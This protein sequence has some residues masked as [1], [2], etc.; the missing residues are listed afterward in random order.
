MNTALQH[1][2]DTTNRQDSPTQ[3]KIQ[4]S[5]VDCPDLSIFEGKQLLAGCTSPVWRKNGVKYEQVWEVDKGTD[6]VSS[7]TILSS[8]S[9]MRCAIAREL[10]ECED[11]TRTSQLRTESLHCRSGAIAASKMSTAISK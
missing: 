7:G 6:Q 5:K 9:S 8:D 10:D 3:V 1:Q 11:M 4:Q 2:I